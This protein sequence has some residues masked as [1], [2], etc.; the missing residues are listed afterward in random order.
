M[1]IYG[2]PHHAKAVAESETELDDGNEKP[3]NEL[4][5]DDVKESVSIARGRGLKFLRL[6][7]VQKEDAKPP[8]VPIPAMSPAAAS[9]VERKNEDTS[10]ISSEFSEDKDGVGDDVGELIN[11]QP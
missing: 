9:F 3:A 11:S 10:S 8:N 5:D 4:D 6:V 2:L 7:I 1:K